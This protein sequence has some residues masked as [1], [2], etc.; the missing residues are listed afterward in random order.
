MPASTIRFSSAIRYRNPAETSVPAIPP[1]VSKAEFG[2]TTAPNTARAATTM[3]APTAITTLAWPRE[4]KNPEASGRWP[5]AI[6]LRVVLSMAEMWSASKACL[7]PRNHAVTA[8]PSPT[9]SP[10]LPPSPR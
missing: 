7:N 10:W 3:P 8:T 1:A 5:S 2:L 6:S 4:K 9:P